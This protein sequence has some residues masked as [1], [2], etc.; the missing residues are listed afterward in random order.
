MRQ[1]GWAAKPDARDKTLR[2]ADSPRTWRVWSAWRLYLDQG[3]TNECVGYA[4]SHLLDCAPHRQY[5]DA[6]GIYDLAKH[7]DEWA[8]ENYEG[9]SCRAAMK[10]LKLLGY[11]ASYQRA[12]SAETIARHVLQVGP[13]L[14]G[15]DWYEGMSDPDAS[16]RLR[17]EGGLLGGHA[18]LARGFN[19]RTNLFRLKNSWGR[20]WGLRGDAFLAYG[21]LNKLLQ[22]G[23]EAWVGVKEDLE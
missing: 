13:V 10:V 9:T 11:F 23:G 22:A 4:G 20:Q 5:L 8:G 15:L 14:L 1:F 18:I 6:H 3:R 12:K 2:L 7:Y 21:D 17:L 19:R 16:G